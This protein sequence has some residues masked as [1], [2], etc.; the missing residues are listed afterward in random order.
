MIRN[1]KLVQF[2]TPDTVQIFVY[3]DILSASEASSA[4]LEMKEDGVYIF[5]E[6]LSNTACG[7]TTCNQ[8][9]GKKNFHKI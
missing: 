5:E 6:I 4:I 1:L 8:H 3:I 2:P 7:H 9:Q